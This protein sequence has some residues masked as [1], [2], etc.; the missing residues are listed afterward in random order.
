[1]ESEMSATPV[2]DLGVGIGF[3]AFLVAALAVWGGLHLRARVFDD[4]E[5]KVELAY[6]DLQERATEIFA[7]LRSSLDEVAP[8]AGAPFNPDMVVADLAPVGK[9]AK[10]VVRVLK[11]RIRIR[12]QFRVLLVVCSVAK[13]LSLAFAAAVLIATLTYL[14]LYEFVSIWSLA[15]LLGIITFGLGVLVVLIYGI[16]GSLLQTSYEHS[17]SEFKADPR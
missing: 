13:W 4:W 16:L 10:R 17:K 1:M 6:A 11:E 9:L 15:I 3:A 12:R 5:R 2:I 7:E 14:F 8:S